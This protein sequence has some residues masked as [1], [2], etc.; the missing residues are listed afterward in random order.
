MVKKSKYWVR[1]KVL[2]VDTPPLAAGQRWRHGAVHAEQHTRGVNLP[3]YAPSELQ[4]FSA[5]KVT[6]RACDV[7]ARNNPVSCN[8]SLKWSK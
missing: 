4:G 6:S 7:A 8:F 3:C 5:M 1:S 2:L